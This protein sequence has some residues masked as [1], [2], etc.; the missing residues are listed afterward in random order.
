MGSVPIKNEDNKVMAIVGW[1]WWLGVIILAATGKKDEDEQLKY[2]FY[3]VLL[4]SI[5]TTICMFFTWL[6]IPG[7]IYIVFMI[8]LL[9]GFIMAITGKVWDA[10]IAGGWAK[11]K[12]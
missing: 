4:L 9:I 6:I 5:V 2:I 3:Q 10:P 8:F 1:L 12:L 11:K 7:I